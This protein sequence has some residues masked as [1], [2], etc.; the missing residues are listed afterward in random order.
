MF[1]NSI[2]S[3]DELNAPF[4]EL[5]DHAFI[6]AIRHYDD[7]YPDT[8][9]RFNLQDCM[10]RKADGTFALFVAVGFPG[11]API[12]EPMTLAEVFE[13]YQECPEQIERVVVG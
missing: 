6:F 10:V 12:E 9:V 7:W 8:G 13:W 11:D 3:A 1:T 2:H 4:E 5:P